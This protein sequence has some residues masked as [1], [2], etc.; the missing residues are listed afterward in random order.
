MGAN[1]NPWQR[2]G[3]VLMV[4]GHLDLFSSRVTTISKGE[5]GSIHF[6]GISPCMSTL[7]AMVVGASDPGYP[8]RHYQVY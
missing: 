6:P 2:A 4:G 1:H 7:T 8:L 5:G 3:P